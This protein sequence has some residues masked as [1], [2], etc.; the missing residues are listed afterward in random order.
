MTE[1]NHTVTIGELR[2]MIKVKNKRLCLRKERSALPPETRGNSAT[3][4]NQFMKERE[5]NPRLLGNPAQRHDTHRS[6]VMALDADRMSF[7]RDE[8]YKLE[9]QIL[10]VLA[11]QPIQIA[12]TH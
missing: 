9:Y 11:R 2:D 1:M 3:A 12:V 7:S 8:G 5:K 4:A 6:G 10:R